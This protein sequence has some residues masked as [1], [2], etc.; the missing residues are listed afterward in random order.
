MTTART[1]EHPPIYASL[2]AELGDVLN[3]SRA[4]A[5]RTQEES[6]RALDWNALGR[7]G[8]EGRSDRGFSAFG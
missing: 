2:V 5:R 1:P 7:P 3:E 4:V 6:R 8:P